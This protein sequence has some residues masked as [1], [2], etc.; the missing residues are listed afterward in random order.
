MQADIAYLDPCS[1]V[2]ALWKRGREVFR[3][4]FFGQMSENDVMS[5]WENAR[6]HAEWFQKHEAS[7]QDPSTWSRLAPLSLYGDDISTYKSTE[8]GS[9]SIIGFSSDFAHGNPPFLR[10]LPLENLTAKLLSG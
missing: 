7:R 5:Y 1:L 2:Q 6:D 9:T 8:A 3:R 10:Y 4:V